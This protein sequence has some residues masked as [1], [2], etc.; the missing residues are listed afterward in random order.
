MKQIVKNFNNLINKTI[1]KLA[2]KTN[3]NFH[4]STFNKC[5]IAII[6]ILFI[7]IF[8]LLIPL[9]YDK[10]WLQ[11]KI[12]EKLKDEFNII[13]IDT[14][15]ISYRILPRPHF[16][17]KNSTISLAKLG[18][19]NIY[20]NQ[21]NLFNKNNLNI[22]EVIINEA[23]FSLLKDDFKELSVNTKNKFPNKK[24]KINNS[25][26]FFKDN[27][28]EVSLII[29]ISN[30]AIFFDRKKLLNLIDL[31]GSVFNIPFS[32]DYQHTLNSKNNKRIEIVA[33]N[34]RLKIINESFKLGENLTTGTNS[35]SILN[36][37]VNTKF[38]VLDEVITFESGSSRIQNSKINYNGKLAVN[39]F[40]LDLKINLDNY[41]IYNLLTSDSIINEFI[42]S[43]LLFNENISTNISININ[44]KIRNKIFHDANIKFNILNG[45]INFDNT[46]F[47]NDDIGLLKITNSDLFLKN[48]KLNLAANLSIDI[49]DIDKLF[50]FLNTSKK[51]RKDFKNIKLNIIY[52]FLS[53]QIE[54]KDIK[55]DNKEVSGQFQNITEDLTDNNF[56]NLTKSRVIL[57]KL[58]NLYEG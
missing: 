31:R 39:P 2:N 53:N 9:L 6:S 45:K 52:D 8:Y 29:K 48:D 50:S 25:N 11:N 23:N 38:N 54:F 18:I 3:N 19:V 34:L 15:N 57:N 24:I 55:I 5:V 58:I 44:S 1:F 56:N 36:S 33:D 30:A 22:N 41:K 35:I 10:N 42:K 16:S 49:K 27:L 26:I 12:T 21:N 17:I 51:S 32:L 7:Y 46:I 13:L 20:I 4:V 28:G 37:T 43:K 14:S 47:T 40:D